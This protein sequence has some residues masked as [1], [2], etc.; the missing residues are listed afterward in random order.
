MKEID[1]K[2]L[3]A[4][5]AEGKTMLL[6]DVREPNELRSPP[7]RIEGVINIPLGQLLARLPE[8]ATW[9]DK[10]VIS[11]CRSGA[12]AVSAGRA[13]EAGGFRD[14]VLLSGGMMMYNR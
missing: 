13:L 9:K 14:V 2:G 6:L 12:R 10:T 4:W 11:I 8:I 5:L 3:K 1:A 7:G